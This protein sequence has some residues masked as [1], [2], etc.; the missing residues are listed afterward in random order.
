MEAEDGLNYT[1]LREND[2]ETK[3]KM[4]K[5]TELDYEDRLNLNFIKLKNL[6]EL[7]NLRFSI[8]DLKN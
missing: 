7:E 3:I 6:E 4:L 8:R 2:L 1:L 5:K